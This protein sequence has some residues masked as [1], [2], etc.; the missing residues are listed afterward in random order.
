VVSARARVRTIDAVDHPPT[1]SVFPLLDYPRPTSKDAQDHR[2]GQ[3]YRAS[4]RHLS[5]AA[6][7]R[8]LVYE[9]KHQ[10]MNAYSVL[11][12]MLTA[13]SDGTSYKLGA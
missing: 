1:L 5:E 6:P 13:R 9:D 8:T 12:P 4:R 10:S 11:T 7:N 3:Q 2:Y